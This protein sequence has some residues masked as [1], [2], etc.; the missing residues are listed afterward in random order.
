MNIKISKPED[1]L[2][3][4]EFAAKHKLPC[5]KAVIKAVTMAEDIHM[6]QGKVATYQFMLKAMREEYA[7]KNPLIR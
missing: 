7:K 3:I 2:L 4:R 5:T 6:M 1:E